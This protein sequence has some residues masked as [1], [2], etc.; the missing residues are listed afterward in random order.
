MDRNERLS[1]GCAPPRHLSVPEGTRQLRAIAH[2][3][4]LADPTSPSRWGPTLTAVDAVPAVRLVRHMSGETEHAGRPIT[5]ARAWDGPVGR[6]VTASWS[7]S[8]HAPS[9]GRGRHRRA[10]SLGIEV[11]ARL[12]TGG[13][14]TRGEDL[15]GIAVDI[16]TRVFD[17]VPDRRH[18]STESRFRIPRPLPQQR[19]TTR[20]PTVQAPAH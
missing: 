13:C 19:D 2:S 20:R 5:I 7:A 8:R 16:A 10:R 17:C 6:S 14:E 12:H 3:D 15:A 1:A 11:R 18:A 9:A 4:D